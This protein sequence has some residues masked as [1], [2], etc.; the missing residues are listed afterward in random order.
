MTEPPHDP[1]EERLR[2]ILRAEAD[3][4]DPS[5][6]ALNAIRSRTQRTSWATVLLNA[7]WLRPSLAVGAAALIVG[8]VLL[9]TP[10]VRD[11]I[12]PQSLTTPASESGTSPRDDPSGDGAPSEAPSTPGPAELPS[13]GAVPPPGSPSPGPTE[14]D[15]TPLGTDDPCTA[16]SPA[17]RPSASPDGT[18]DSA[19]GTSGTGCGSTEEPSDPTQEPPPD[20][21]GDG[22]EGDSSSPPDDGAGGGDGGVDDGTSTT[23]PDDTTSGSGEGDTAMAGVA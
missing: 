23:P 3:S 1:I 2:A 11:Q 5:P 22:S 16:G 8:S 18:G 17:P 10:Q 21:P 20:D 7:S 14:G 4:V 19:D 12:L 13:E 15:S 9:G 6:E